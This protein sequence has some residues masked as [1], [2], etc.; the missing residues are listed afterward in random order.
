MTDSPANEPPADKESDQIPA[1]PQSEPEPPKDEK[2]DTRTPEQQL[3]DYEESLKN[4]D[5]GHQPC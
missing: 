5:W 1:A 3:A 4:D 2:E